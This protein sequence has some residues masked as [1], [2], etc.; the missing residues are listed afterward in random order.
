MNI[1]IVVYS[2]TGNTES[3]ARKI[4]DTLISSGHQVTY[5]KI[6]IEGEIKGIKRDVK[7]INLPDIKPYDAIIFATYVEAFSLSQVMSAYLKKV[8]DLTGKKAACLTT[9]FFPYKW[10]GGNHAHK[11]MRALLTAKGA[12]FLGGYDVNWKKKDFGR[13]ERIRFAVDKISNLF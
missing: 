5:L 2:R 6:E 8:D 3:V 13:K 11:Q 7:F 10:M 1:G 12:E 9:Q 4:M